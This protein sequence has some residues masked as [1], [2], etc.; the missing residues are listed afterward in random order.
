MRKL[1]AFAVSLITLASCTPN[2]IYSRA[3]ENK[4]GKAGIVVSPSN[5]VFEIV[6]NP[7]EGTVTSV[8]VSQE[9]IDSILNK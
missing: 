6:V 4:L 3:E 9:R 5:Q 8:Y 1:F 7:T 2:H